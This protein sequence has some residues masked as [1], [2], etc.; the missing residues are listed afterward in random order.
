[1][2]YNL[3][4]M[5]KRLN[6]LRPIKTFS[7]GCWF[8]YIWSSSLYNRLQ[9]SKDE[10]LYISGNFVRWLPYF[11]HLIEVML[12]CP[13]W[14][15]TRGKPLFWSNLSPR[16]R[17]LSSM[18]HFTFCFCFFFCFLCIKESISILYSVYIASV[19]REF[20]VTV[21]KLCIWRFHSP[22]Q[23]HSSRVLAL[24]LSSGHHSAFC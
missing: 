15:V 7:L 16:S 21:W 24:S 12:F 20:G 17:S 2:S 4:S 13:C 3:V 8:S 22:L 14:N 1:M 11:L 6:L 9:N 5:L 19:I 23:L 18:F 10:S